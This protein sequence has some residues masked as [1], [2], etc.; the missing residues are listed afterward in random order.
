M[1]REE[2]PKDLRQ[3]VSDLLKDSI[4]TS[5][6]ETI[7]DSCKNNVTSM[8][9]ISEAKDGQLGRKRLVEVCGVY[10]PELLDALNQ[11]S[12]IYENPTRVVK[13]VFG[14]DTPDEA[15]LKTI[16]DEIIQSFMNLYFPQELA[17]QVDL[18]AEKLRVMPLIRERLLDYC[19][20]D[21]TAIA[22]IKRFK[23]IAGIPNT[24]HSNDIYCKDLN[25][26][27]LNLSGLDLRGHYFKIVSFN[28]SDLSNCQFKDVSRCTFDDSNL[29][30]ASFRDGCLK[31]EEVSF[32]RA[33]LSWT[34]F[35]G[36]EIEKGHSWQK[37]RTAAEVKAELISRGGANVDHAIFTDEE[38]DA[39]QYVKLIEARA[40]A[41]VVAERER[42]LAELVNRDNGN[43]N[44]IV[45]NNNNAVVNLEDNQ[46]E[47][48]KFC[49]IL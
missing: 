1:M 37:C 48:P 2:P 24:G 18:Q 49:M 26:S 39:Y 40:R 13:S 7:I 41:R 44:N 12:K 4:L 14:H 36:V 16:A 22:D 6:L 19:R 28:N 25:L 47:R 35:T 8:K 9:L 10:D 3:N 32:L 33:D 30:E 17:Q 21:M 11:I 15:T 31:G 29:R 27:N 23:E 38:F 43:D 42:R 45:P 20:G 46:E 5:I 34:D